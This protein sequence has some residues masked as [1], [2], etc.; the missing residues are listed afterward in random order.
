MGASP[1]IIGFMVILMIA[2]LVEIYDEEDEA[3]ADPP[4]L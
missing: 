4:S 1:W 3:P 2:L